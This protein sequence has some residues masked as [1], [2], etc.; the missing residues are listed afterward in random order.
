MTY[1]SCLAD[2]LSPLILDTS[3]L[4]N[5]HASTY[6]AR[7][8]TALPNQAAVSRIVSDEL[9]HETSVVN[10]DR[11]FI[12]GL[13][14]DHKMQILEMTDDEYAIFEQLVSG[15]DS[16]DDGEAATIA[17]ASCRGYLPVI[18]ERKGR[19]RSQRLIPNKEPAW[20][21]D[22]FLHPCVITA[23]EGAAAAEAIYLALCDGRMRI[24]EDCVDEVVGLIGANR[25][26]DCRSLPGYKAR[27]AAWLSA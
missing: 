25:A 6:G 27:A 11:R 21:I 8:F 4:I 20:S 9:E 17:I 10:G 12:D 5:L 15:S 23:L 13:I 7:I 2:D 14:S 1:S 24:H 3:V 22:L 16:L 18:D 19:Q 26:L